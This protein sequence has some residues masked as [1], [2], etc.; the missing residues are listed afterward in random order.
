MVEKR[1]GRVLFISSIAG[2]NGGVVGAHY[3]ASKAGLHGLT[4]H[5]ANKTPVVPRVC[6]DTQIR[7]DTRWTEKSWKGR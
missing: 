2:L 7:P 4:Q 6:Q 1:F 5:L 3:A